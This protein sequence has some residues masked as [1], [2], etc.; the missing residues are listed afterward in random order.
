MFFTATIGHPEPFEEPEKWSKDF[1]DFIGKCL[2]KSPQNRAT[3]EQLLK[4]QS[5]AF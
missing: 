3:A 5:I 2:Q 4:V 1:H